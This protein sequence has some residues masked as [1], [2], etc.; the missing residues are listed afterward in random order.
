MARTLVE[1]YGMQYL[2]NID[3]YDYS[4]TRSGN[5]FMTHPNRKPYNC[6]FEAVSSLTYD[7]I[8]ELYSDSTC[9]IVDKTEK[10]IIYKLLY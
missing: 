3:I 1:G 10:F 6:S 8:K 9:N 7:Y 5:P 4:M 2:G